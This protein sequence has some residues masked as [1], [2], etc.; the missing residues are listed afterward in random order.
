MEA[1]GKES[2]LCLSA[3]PFTFRGVIFVSPVFGLLYI[4]KNLMYSLVAQVDL[5]LL[6]TQELPFNNLD[7]PS[8]EL[9]AGLGRSGGLGK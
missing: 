5:V 8:M 6:G 2:F 9:L 7:T 4:R 1:L 3:A